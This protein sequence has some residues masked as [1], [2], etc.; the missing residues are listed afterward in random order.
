MTIILGLDMS[1]TTIG[2]ALANGTRYGHAS[3]LGDIAQRCEAARYY[4]AYLLDAYKPTLV[5][6]E[7]PVA[8][9]AKALIPQ[10]R[11]SGAVLAE[12]ARRRT[13]WHE[14]APS[15]AKK[16]LTGY[17]NASKTLMIATAIERLGDRRI[18]EHAA[19]A[20]G[21]AIAGLSIEIITEK[22]P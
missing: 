5:I 21:L 12:F 2:Y 6:I 10:A 20:Y 9:Y 19:D 3:I 13:L 1:S 18:S 15:V 11:V 22:H 7:S 8:R 4:V 17:G 16:A 14:V